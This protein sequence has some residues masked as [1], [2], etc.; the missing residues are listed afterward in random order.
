[1]REN[2]VKRVFVR[3]RRDTEGPMLVRNVSQGRPVWRR[4]IANEIERVY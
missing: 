1:V 2:D 3:I 4:V